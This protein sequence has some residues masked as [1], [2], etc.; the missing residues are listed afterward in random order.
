MPKPA[1]TLDQQIEL[2]QERGMEFDNFKEAKHFLSNISYYRLAGYWWEMQEDR[3]DHLFLE[4]S[5][6]NDVIQLYN[7]DRQFRLIVFDAIERLEIALR[8]KL[9]YHL[10]LKSGGLWYEDASLFSKTKYHDEQLE[11]IREEVERSKEEFIVKHKENHPNESPEAW[12]ALE[13]VTL[14][15]LSK[16]YENLKDQLPEKSKI[17][18]EFGLYFHSDFSSWLRTT[19]YLRNLIAHHSR[20]WNRYIIIKYSWPRSTSTPILNYTPDNHQTRKIF[21][22]LSGILH[23]LNQVSPGHGVKLKLLELFRNYPQTP[24]SKMG[25]PAGW[26]NQPIWRK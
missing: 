12:K 8:T 9:I 3:I 5:S 7:F 23:M 11:K 19:T 17:A 4:G 1:F 24:L 10:S 16:Q 14:N 20:L 6:F 2:L 26:D 21:P 15:T 18:N 13:V 25:F 22:I